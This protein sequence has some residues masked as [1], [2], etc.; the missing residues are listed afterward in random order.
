MTTAEKFL[1]V[2]ATDLMPDSQTTLE[3]GLAIALGA[4]GRLV[5][6]HVDQG[7]PDGPLPSAAKVL[8]KWGKAEDAVAHDTVVASVDKKPKK[9]LLRTLH[10]LTP[11][12]LIVGTRQQQG[13]QKTFRESAAEV[14]AL[15]AQIPTLVLHLGQ[16]GLIDDKGEVSIRRVLLPVGDG[17][18]ARDAIR[19]LTMFFDNLGVTDVD[20]FLFRVGDDEIFEYLTL[21]ER[22]G[23][24]FH[25]ERAKGYVS[26]AIG[27]ACESKDIDL[28]AMSTRGQ[29]GVVDVFSGTHTQK[30]IRRVPCPVLV[31]PVF[32]D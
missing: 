21:P 3:H 8:K 1:V 15:D 25:R 28:I 11:D 20:I 27:D 30:V 22:D 10:D 5:S 2:Q 9:G 19:G 13:E 18:E 29:D 14:A 7:E 6:L 4:E 17:A 26:T 23:W 16:D 31:S 32:D 24:R 12:L